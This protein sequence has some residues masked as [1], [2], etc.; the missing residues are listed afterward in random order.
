MWQSAPMIPQKG[1]LSLAFT[2]IELL[3][4]I[5]IIA[6]LASMILPALSKAKEKAYTT[7]CRSNLKQMGIASTLYTQDNEDKLPYAWG[8][9]IS[10][11]IHDANR[12]NFETLLYPYYGRKEFDA[13][14]EGKNFT[15][16]VSVCPIRLKENHWQHYKK[17][18]GVGNPWKISYGM[19]QHTSLNFPNTRG[20]FPSSDTARLSSIRLPAKTHLISDLSYELNHPAIITMG[21][22]RS[23]GYHDVGY[24]HSGSHPKAKANILMIDAHLEFAS[25][26]AQSWVIMDFKKNI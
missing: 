2:L 17:Y 1:K 8:A 26:N 4:V 21:R 3:V 12:N 23:T 20:E 13:S 9:G 15:N 16:F 22:H 25:T 10:T 19:N 14:R 7:K 11:F 5:A 24:K 6:I 18:Q